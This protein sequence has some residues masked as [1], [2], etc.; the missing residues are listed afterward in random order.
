M[1]FLF[2]MSDNFTNR[3]LKIIKFSLV[4]LTTSFI[5]RTH[6]MQ[7]FIHDSKNPQGILNSQKFF[8]IQS[9]RSEKN[10]NSTCHSRIRSGM[11]LLSSFFWVFPVGQCI[12]NPGHFGKLLNNCHKFSFYFQI[13]GV[14]KA[15]LEWMCNDIERHSFCKSNENNLEWIKAKFCNYLQKVNSVSNSCKFPKTLIHA[16]C[17]ISNVYKQRF[18]KLVYFFE[19]LSNSTS[20]F[21]KHKQPQ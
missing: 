1:C 17:F 21:E 4:V 7:S 15:D 11:A 13:V 20:P 16:L 19:N 12:S 5:I 8:W 10:S 6:C 2:L 3:F 9:K 14:D 18:F